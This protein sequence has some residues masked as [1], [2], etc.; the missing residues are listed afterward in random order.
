MNPREITRSLGG[1][2]QLFRGRPEGLLALDRTLGGFWRSFA[3]IA[4]VVPLNAVTVLSIARANGEGD[5]RSLFGDGLPVLAADWIAF[6]L[7]LA[8]FAG[9]LGVNRTYPSYVV[10]RNWAA[11]I[12]AALVM[13]PFLLQG[14]GW[15][16]PSGTMFLSLIAFALVLRYHFIVLRLALQTTVPISL[17]LMLVDLLLTLLLVALLD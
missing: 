17:A 11:P 2:W 14:A 10:A 3:V 13:V 4:L 9:P 15:I 5:F 6:P 8:L 1:A 16:G 7:A 12:A